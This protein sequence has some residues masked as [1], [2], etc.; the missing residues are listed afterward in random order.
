MDIDVFFTAD[1]VDPASVAGR[2]AVV[3]DVIRATSTIVTALASGARAV[4]PTVSTEEALKLASSLG[5][6]DALLCGERKG[7]K[8]EGFD[9]GNSPAEFTADTV[10]EKQLVMSTTNGTRALHA[11][12]GASRVVVASFLNLGAVAGSLEGEESLAVICAGKEGVFSLDD[13][14]CAGAILRLLGVERGAGHTMNDAAR[15][16]L[17]LADTFEPTPAF[18]AATAAGQA[19]VEVGLESDLPLVARVDEY[20]I[21]PEMQERAIRL[22]DSPTGGR[23]ERGAGAPA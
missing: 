13:A 9:L 14:V 2:T 17:S 8:I 6:E 15:A 19:L 16:S 1:Q 22:P 11:A 4:F 3:I 12:A 5:R 21:V 23:K 20:P 10:G 18:M 7:V